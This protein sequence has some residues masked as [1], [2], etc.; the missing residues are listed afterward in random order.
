MADRTK[1]LNPLNDFAFKKILGE[2]GDEPQL[3]AFLNA[4]LQRTGKGTITDLE[5][6]ENRDI[7][8]E[9]PDGKSAKLDVRANYRTA[10]VSTSKC[11]CRTSTT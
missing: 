11:S 7:P 6:V 9:T 10:L 5:I 8:A 1:R 3:I 2:K 4:V